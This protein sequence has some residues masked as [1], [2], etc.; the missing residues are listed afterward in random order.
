M[1]WSAWRQVSSLG[2]ATT[3]VALVA[4][5]APAASGAATFEVN[6]TSDDV[7]AMIDGR[8]DTNASLASGSW[9]ASFDAIPAAANLTALQTDATDG[10]SELALVVAP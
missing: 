6:V 10:S 2:I 5:L 1:M 4:L 9:S 8:C 7:D 3:A